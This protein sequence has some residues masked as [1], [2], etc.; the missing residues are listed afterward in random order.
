MD[1][2]ANS[3]SSEVSSCSSCASTTKEPEGNHYTCRRHRICCMTSTYDPH[4][5]DICI[6]NRDLWRSTK[7]VPAILKWRSTLATFQKN[8]KNRLFHYEKPFKDFFDVDSLVQEV[9]PRPTTPQ[10]VTS[11]TDDDSFN[12]RLQNSDVIKEMRES[13][14]LLTQ[15]LLPQN[16]ASQPSTSE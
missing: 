3:P 7:D 1:I 13:L 16:T 4:A 15:H 6:N 2:Q 8:S 9:S 11:H 14:Q 5:C 10:S 12:L